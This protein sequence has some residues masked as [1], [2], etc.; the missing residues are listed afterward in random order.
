MIDVISWHSHKKG[1]KVERKE[2]ERDEPIRDIIHIH[3]EM[4]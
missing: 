2:M 1:T 3:M 4:S